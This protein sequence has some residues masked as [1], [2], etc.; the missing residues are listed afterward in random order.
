MKK[1]K[2]SP[3]GILTI[4]ARQ[5]F[6]VPHRDDFR[7]SLSLL[8]RVYFPLVLVLQCIPAYTHTHTLSSLL[9]SKSAQW[10][11]HTAAHQGPS[12]EAPRRESPLHTC[13]MSSQAIRRETVSVARP[14]LCWR[15]LQTAAFPEKGGGCCCCCCLGLLFFPPGD[16][17]REGGKTREEAAAVGFLTSSLVCPTVLYLMIWLGIGL[18]AVCSRVCLFVYWVKVVAGVNGVVC[19]CLL[20]YLWF[21]GR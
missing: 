19:V 20:V 13:S 12:E 1:K 7:I 6:K 14:R 11:R 10:R 4:S 18:L 21:V 17:F 3:L 15:V 5:L 16:W 8:R 2:T 9:R